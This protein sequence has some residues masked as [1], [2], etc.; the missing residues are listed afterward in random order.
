MR[1]KGNL[2]RSSSLVRKMCRKGALSIERLYSGG[3]VWSWEEDRAFVLGA[4]QEDGIPIF[5]SSKQWL[6]C[7]TLFISKIPNVE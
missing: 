4:V 6:G 2:L 3:S 7:R 5:R 1:K